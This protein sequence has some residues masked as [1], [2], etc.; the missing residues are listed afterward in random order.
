MVN[1]ERVPPGMVI[2]SDIGMIFG[3]NHTTGRNWTR[4]AGFPSFKGKVL[5]GS[6]QV[7]YFSIKEIAEFFDERGVKYRR[8]V[9]TKIPAEFNFYKMF[10]AVSYARK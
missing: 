7:R 4:M 3:I 5:R 10:H 6:A 8:D 9:K 1:N 2:M